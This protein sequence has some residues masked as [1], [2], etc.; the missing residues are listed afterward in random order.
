MIRQFARLT[1]VFRLRAPRIDEGAFQQPLPAAISHKSTARASYDCELVGVFDSLRDSFTSG[2][3]LAV[4]RLIREPGGATRGFGGH[5]PPISTVK[6]PRKS[7]KSPKSG[8]A[9]TLLVSGVVRKNHN[10]LRLEA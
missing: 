1:A 2:A 3:R 8:P 4:D 7:P 9:R 10:F 6:I 5:S